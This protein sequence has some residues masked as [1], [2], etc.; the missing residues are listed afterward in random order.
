M[1]KLVAARA[2]SRRCSR[3]RRRRRRIRS[4]TSRSTTSARVEVSGHRIYV[5]YVLD[6]AEIPTFQG[7]QTRCR[8]VRERIARGCTSTVGGRRSARVVVAHALAL[9]MGAGGL[10][11]TRLAGDPARAPRCAGAVQIA[12]TRTTPAGSAG[13]KSSSAPTRRVDERRAARV[14]EGACSR[15]RSTTRSATATLGADE[16]FRRRGADRQGAL[17]APDRVADSGFAR[18]IGRGDLR[19]ARHPRLARGRSL[20]GR[21]ACALA[22]P[23]QDDRHRLPRREPGHAAA[24]GAARPHHHGHAHDRCLRA[25][26]RDARALGVHRPGHAISMDQRCLRCARRQRRRSRCSP[27]AGAQRTHMPSTRTSTTTTSTITST[28]TRMA[29]VIII[30]TRAAAEHARSGCG[31]D[32]R[33]PAPVSVRARRAARRNLA[34][35]RGVRAALIVAFSLGLAL[36]ITGIG[37]LA[38]FAKRAFGRLDM[39]GG[40]I[41]FLPALSALVIV[42]AGLAMTVR[43]IPQLHI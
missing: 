39:N 32:L 9:P 14:S 8:R 17:Q 37:L 18:L 25:R 19:V 2:G 33:R 41:R 22:G 13:R 15:A 36:T 4:A 28:A 26:R 12:T 24:R 11:T 29:P 31:R 3:S 35:S 27:A 43:A 16:R 7:Q 42:V 10:H 38:V 21:R 5:R 1:K 34:A 20:L 30:T 23:R 6:L 40:L